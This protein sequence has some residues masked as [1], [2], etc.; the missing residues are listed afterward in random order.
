MQEI[1]GLGE[2]KPFTLA[3]QSLGLAVTTFGP[4]H[5]ANIGTVTLTLQGSDFTSQTVVSLQRGTGPLLSAR[6]WTFRTAVPS[7]PRST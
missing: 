2:C 1:A 7:T 3:A 6:V 5:G 4:T